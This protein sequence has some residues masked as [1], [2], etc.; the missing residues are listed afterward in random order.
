MPNVKPALVRVRPD[1]LS[2]WAASQNVDDPFSDDP[3]M[4]TQYVKDIY[5]FLRKSEVSE[6]W[7][8]YTSR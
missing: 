3:L 4:C 2:V 8:L 5:S 6:C 7:H 1:V